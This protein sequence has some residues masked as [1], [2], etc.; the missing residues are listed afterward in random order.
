M[1]NNR[2][3]QGLVLLGWI[4][5]VFLM[6]SSAANAGALR[7]IEGLY[8]PWGERGWSCSA[9]EIGSMKGALAIFGR[10]IHGVEND[11]RI[12][13]VSRRRAWFRLR[14]RCAGEGGT[15]TDTLHVRP[16]RNGLAFKSSEGY[17]YKWRR[18]YR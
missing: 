11:C 18:C 1:M 9:H 13:G 12:I 17:R 15:Y 3:K 5:I 6:S 8:Y 4:A 2:L 14:L 7:Q 16:I 10:T